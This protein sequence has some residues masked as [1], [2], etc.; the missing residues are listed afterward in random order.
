VIV[1]IRLGREMR[2]VPVLED[3]I[4]HIV[5]PFAA[6]AT[7]FVSGIVANW[8]E[9]GAL[10]VVAAVALVLMLVGIH[11]AWDAALYIAMAKR[12]GESEGHEP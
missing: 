1:K 8:H 6:Y 3:R 11:N 7:L 9:V 12:S 5:L 2:Y 4:F 10:Y